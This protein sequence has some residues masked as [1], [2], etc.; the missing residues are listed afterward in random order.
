MPTIQARMHKGRRREVSDT[1]L[2]AD[3]VADILSEVAHYLKQG[4]Y[5]FVVYAGNVCVTCKESEATDGE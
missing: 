1:K 4:V 3:Q 2:T 5:D